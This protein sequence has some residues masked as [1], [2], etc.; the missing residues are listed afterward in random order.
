[1]VY[2]TVDEPKRGCAL[3]KG[4]AAERG[5]GGEEESEQERSVERS[6]EHLKLIMPTKLGVYLQ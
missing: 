5:E 3:V 1:M 4:G 6:A 2:A